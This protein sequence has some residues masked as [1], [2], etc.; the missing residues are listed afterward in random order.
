VFLVDV[1]VNF[2]L[3]TFRAGQWVTSACTIGAQY[4]RR[5]FLYDIIAAVPWSL[6][7][8]LATGAEGHFALS[9]TLLSLLRVLRLRRL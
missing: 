1:A 5:E 3:A 8:A 6:V 9:L 2:R 7:A 4:V